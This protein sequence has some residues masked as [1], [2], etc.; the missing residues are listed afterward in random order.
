[1]VTVSDATLRAIA[2]NAVRHLLE[3]DRHYKAGQFPS[4]AAS[5]VLSIEEAGKLSFITTHGR[6]P[7]EK[8]H[9]AHAM[10][11]V[12]LL[13]GL[14]QWNW[15]A[16]WT[17]FVVG[18]ADPGELGLTAQQQQDIAAHPELAAFVERL[19]AGELSE[20]EARIK[21]WSEAVDEKEKRDGTFK[22]WDRLFTGG[23]QAI[24]LTA[25]YV[26]VAP[27]GDV[28]TDPNT[29]DDSFAMLMCT[30]AVGFLFLM[31]LLAGHKRKSLEVRDLLERVPGD[32]TGWDALLKAF[33]F[34]AAKAEAA[35]KAGSEGI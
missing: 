12:A 32:V 8:R 19:Q 4:A 20:S 34:L 24:R 17:K 23:L 35:N 13:K 11:F 27:S 21:A 22:S 7:K 3:A 15:Y 5:A 9:A 18:G 2:A 14:G 16:E 6:V 30:G 33:P 26:D 25:T 29:I 1:M 10:V 28:K 31:L